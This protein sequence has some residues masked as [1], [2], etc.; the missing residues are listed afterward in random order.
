MCCTQ[1]GRLSLRNLHHHPYNHKDEKVELHI[2]HFSSW[3]WRVC[4]ASDCHNRPAHI[5]RCELHG[6]RQLRA[7]ILGHFCAIARMS[8]IFQHSPLLDIQL[9]STKGVSAHPLM[10]WALPSST[11]KV[12][13]VLA[14]NAY[15]FQSFGMAI[16]CSIP[17]MIVHLTSSPLACKVLLSIMTSHISPISNICFSFGHSTFLP[18]SSWIIT[19]C[20]RSCS[21]YYISI[22]CLLSYS[23]ETSLACRSNITWRFMP[24][25]SSSLPCK[26]LQLWDDLVD[27][28]IRQEYLK[29]H[30][31]VSSRQLGSAHLAW[32]R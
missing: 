11:Q 15:Y 13:S 26:S 28:Q 21:Y 7:S 5:R 1:L 6:Y 31:I 10:Y 8:S 12:S 18:S 20:L 23:I 2:N 14:F 32:F 22:S 3:H 29:W 17:S 4:R 19:F 30:S 27:F 24:L 25:T 16:C 9:L